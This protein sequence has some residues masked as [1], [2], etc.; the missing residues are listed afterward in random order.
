MNSSDSSNAVFWILGSVFLII[1]VLIGV[2]IIISL[3]DIQT[4]LRF[5]DVAC[6]DNAGNY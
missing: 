2:G 5:M 6:P 3:D 4:T 1:N